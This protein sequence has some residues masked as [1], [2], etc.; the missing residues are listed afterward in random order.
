[1]KSD[2][3]LPLFFLQLL[4]YRFSFRK[5]QEKV[6]V[7]KILATWKLIEKNLFLNNVKE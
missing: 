2:K 1:M 5:L 3:F 4:F 6:W 7:Q